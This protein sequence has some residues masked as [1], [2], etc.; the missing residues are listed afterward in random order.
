MLDKSNILALVGGGEYPKFSINKI[1]IWDDHQGKIISQIRFN[2]EVI[3]V[4]IR[5]DTIIGVLQ[6]KIYILNIATLETIDILETFNNPNGI[7]SASNINNE[8]TIAFPSIK[9]KGKVQIENYLID[10]D[11][12]KKN[13]NKIINAHESQIAY[14][15]INNEGTILATASDKG[16]L[17]RIFLISKG[18]PPIATLRRGAKNARINCLVFDIQSEIIGC[19]SDS[20]TTHL[21]NITDINKLINEKK[22][23]EQKE[24]NKEENNNKKEKN[25]SSKNNIKINIKDK[26]FVKYRTHETQCILGFYQA[27]KMIILTSNGKYYKV[28]Y[29]TKLGCEQKEEGVLLIDNINNTNNTNK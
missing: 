14:L 7:F 27:N 20:G 2:S 26:S 16:T 5:K 9:M 3:K 10:I 13:E 8:L 1:T 28:N 15:S 25:K 23:E 22:N 18:D 19:T 6:E 12:T 4:K 24:G 21:F 17:I 29:D 11:D